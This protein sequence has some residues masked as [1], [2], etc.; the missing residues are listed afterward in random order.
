MAK[1]SQATDPS[2][3]DLLDP[4]PVPYVNPH[5]DAYDPKTAHKRASTWPIAGVS[6]V[7]AEEL[8]T[9]RPGSQGTGVSPSQVINLLMTLPS[10]A[11]VIYPPPPAGRQDLRRDRLRRLGR[12]H[13]LDLKID[14]LR[15]GD[16]LVA[17]SK[18]VGRKPPRLQVLS[19][20]EAQRAIHDDALPH[21]PS[22]SR[23][24]PD[25]YAADPASDWRDEYVPYQLYL[26]RLLELDSE[27]PG[28]GVIYPFHDYK[29][30]RMQLT[31][32]YL[33]AERYGVR[34]ATK[35]V[36]P[37]HA[38]LT[39]RAHVDGGAPDPRRGYE[40]DEEEVVISSPRP[41]VVRIHGNRSLSGVPAAVAIEPT[42]AGT[43]VELPRARTLDMEDLEP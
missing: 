26:K 27:D 32:L 2:W 23:L 4:V 3:F 36:N 12:Y 1:K 17:L 10:G 7:L 19:P 37:T 40:K 42:V 15:T 8:R 13:N 25:P 21:A 20:I 41:G 34:I 24:L 18:E 6:S 14:G 39:V 38:L 22:R 11:T 30:R 35:R 31:R 9:T 33:E 5:F 29:D 28:A 43:P 16:L